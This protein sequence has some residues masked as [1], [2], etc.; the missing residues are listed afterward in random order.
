MAISLKRLLFFAALL[1]GSTLSFGATESSLFRFTRYFLDDYSDQRDHVGGI[2]VINQDRHGFIWVGGK[3]G[4]ARFDGYQA[5]VYK[6]SASNL[7]SL[8]GD[9]VHAIVFDQN[10]VMWI[11]T[12]RGLSRYDEAQDKFINYTHSEFDTN[13]IPSDMVTSLAVTRENQLVIGTMKGLSVLDQQTGA[14]TN[15]FHH[16][17]DASSIASDAIESLHI[18]HR[19]ILWIG[20][21]GGLEAFHLDQGKTLNYGYLEDERLSQ[22]V[23]Q[24]DA[25]FE[26]SQKQLWIGLLNGS[27]YRLDPSRAQVHHFNSVNARKNKGNIWQITES[28]DGKIFAAVDQDGVMI[29]DPRT[30]SFSFVQH[31]PNNLATID[32]NQTR[33]IFED[34]EKDLWVGTFSGALN[35]FNRQGAL[36]RNYTHNKD[37][38][39]GLVHR[40]VTTIEE[41]RDG[42]VWIGTE[43]GLSAF[44]PRTKLF[45]SYRY[46]PDNASGLQANAV[47]SIEE[48]SAGEL[49]IGTWAGGLHRFNR[50]SEEFTNYFPDESDSHSIA[51]RSVWDTQFDGE[52]K[53]WV[54][55]H[56]AGL[57]QYSLATG[58]FTHFPYDP[59]NVQSL[60][61]DDVRKILRTRDGELWIA[62]ENGLNVYNRDVGTFT[63]FFHDSNVPNSLS[64]NRLVCLI[65]HS[66]GDIWIGT[67]GGGIN[68]LQRDTREFK[69]ID[70]K[71][72]LP[73]SHVTSLAEDAQGYVWAGTFTGLARVHP[74]DHED[75]KVISKHHGL[76]GNYINRD[77]LMFSRSGELYAGTTD[78]LSIFKPE[79][80]IVNSEPRK[81]VITDIKIHQQHLE[82][83][84]SALKQA[85]HLTRSLLLDYSQ[86]AFSFEF[87]LLNYR[88]VSLDEYSY[89]LLGYETEWHTAG[90]EHRA[91][92]TNLDPGSYFFEVRDRAQDPNNT[93]SITRI[94]VTITPPWW[95]TWWAYTI[96]V[97]LAVLT[98]YGVSYFKNRQLYYEKKYQERVNANLVR[99]DKLKN[100]FM[101]STSH[102]LRTPINGII[103]IAESLEQTLKSLG[104]EALNKVEMILLS[105]KRLAS[106]VN[107]VLDFSSLSENMLVIRCEPKN[108][109]TVVEDTL[110]L[111]SSLADPKEIKLVNDINDCDLFVLA[112]GNRLQQILLHLVSN[113]IKYSDGGYVSVACK[114]ADDRLEISVRDTGV[115][116][117]AEDQQNIFTEF[118][119][120]EDVDTR[121][122]EGIGLGL[123]LTKKLVELH[124]GEIWLESSLGKGSCFT[125]TLQ[126]AENN[127]DTAC[128]QEK[129]KNG[130]T[131]SADAHEGAKVTILVVDDDTINRMVLTGILALKE[132]QVI[133]ADSGPAALEV[134]SSGATIDLIVLDIMMPDMSGI[135]VCKTLRNTYSPEELP[136]IFLTAKSTE[137]AL[138]ETKEAGGNQL[139]TK[140]T[141]KAELLPCI[142]ELLPSQRGA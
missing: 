53:L 58:V 54:A 72:G 10:D 39:Q 11:G 73:S 47:L 1:F 70:L 75:I 76:I 71:H 114:K 91:N 111:V 82:I 133:E 131:D 14:F 27:I 87:S 9:F 77:S 106:L 127:S 102:E 121:S 12:M 138:A 8:A 126:L 124:G 110:P 32:T 3:N 50:V 139:L 117:S 30:A 2:W 88:A 41:A 28:H 101:A 125:F 5:K 56:N 45:R 69:T 84:H 40:A 21:T 46:E 132:Y 129:R 38:S 44:D 135:D 99:I 113:G 80:L 42:T 36:F 61:W 37:Q 23:T 119:Q 98:I 130:D 120:L 6:H 64:S 142:A 65:E 90:R 107:D 31:D 136:I 89:R 116:I 59:E 55:T 35:H 96:Y 60:S 20:T 118:F 134:M 97:I 4:L 104:G 78:G 83:G 33:Y 17:D 100:A 26:D 62:T 128:N 109:Y 49:W 85:P 108:I 141:S 94:A 16:A 13:S 66:S 81:A 63:S 34:R 123:A 115:G 7:H 112:D 74:G 24:V 103:G 92:Y 48:D 52:D 95:M 93:E 122:N 19:D 22:G 79:D 29:F 51:E 68:V 18:D 137:E 25:I 43:G 140:P 67:E 86:N 15:Y 105:G 57:D